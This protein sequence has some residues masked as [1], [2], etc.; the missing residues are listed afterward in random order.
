MACGSRRTRNSQMPGFGRPS[1][2]KRPTV[3]RK[4]GGS[5]R[6]NVGE[7]ECHQVERCQNQKLQ[8]AGA[9]GTARRGSSAF[10][11]H[12]CKLASIPY[13]RSG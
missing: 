10:Q 13:A 3:C 4:A 9:L 6:L 11:P 7:A 8:N 2:A 5:H 1:V 12:P